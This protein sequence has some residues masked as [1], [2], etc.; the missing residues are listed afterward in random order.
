M[1]RHMAFATARTPARKPTV[2]ALHCSGS[3]GRQWRHLAQALGHDFRV[4]APELIGAGTTPHWHDSRPLR[5]ADEAAQVVDV[6]DALAGP[7]HVVGH[8]Y[9]GGVALRVARERPA[10]IAS[11]ALHEPT[12]FHVLKAAG[13]EGW[14]ALNDIRALAAAGRADVASGHRGAAAERFIDFWNGKGTW[15]AL[16]P[17]S[18]AELI[19]YAPKIGHDFSASIDE[20]TP[21]AAYRRFRFPVLLLRGARTQEAT[22]L[23]VRRLFSVLRSCAVEEVADAGHM[24][25]LSHAERVSQIIADHVA[26]NEPHVGTATGTDPVALRIAA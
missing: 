23:I 1:S 6:I 13:P 19:R 25:P 5:L 2:V 3:S 17:E 12:A 11:L 16:K 7:V 22:A 9:G 10:R 21:L 14:A 24:G 20:P 18:Q 4:V 15:D 8:S 26:G